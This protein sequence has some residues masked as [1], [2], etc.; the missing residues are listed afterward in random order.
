[1]YNELINKLDKL[2]DGQKYIIKSVN[3][4]LVE[5]IVPLKNEDLKWLISH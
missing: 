4:I 3:L 5:L 2:I 1:M